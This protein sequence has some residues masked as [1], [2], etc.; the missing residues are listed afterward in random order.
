MKRDRRW[1]AIG[2][3]VTRV[4]RQQVGCKRLS[5]GQRRVRLA[6]PGMPPRSP[7][8]FRALAML[9]LG[10]FYWG[11]S[12]PVIKAVGLLH[13]KLLPTASSWFSTLY[14]VAPRFLLAIL[15]MLALRP[16]DCWRASGREQMQ[17]VILGLFAAAGMLLQNDGLQ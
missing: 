9:V 15:L 4:C 10:T 13:E 1:S 17:G 12:F 6:P 14:T 3:G 2:G 5:T 11:L 16:R 8:H 7:D